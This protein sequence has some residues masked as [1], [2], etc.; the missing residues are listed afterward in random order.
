V[1]FSAAVKAKHGQVID[2]MEEAQAARGRLTVIALYAP[3]YIARRI[4]QPTFRP[5]LSPPRVSAF[6][7]YSRRALIFLWSSMNVNGLT[8]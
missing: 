7:C 6:S 4:T 1:S 5:R 8:M 3:P 2:I